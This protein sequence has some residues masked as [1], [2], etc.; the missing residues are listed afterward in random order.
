MSI[1][2]LIYIMA[3]YKLKMKAAEKVLV[4]NFEF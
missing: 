3:I 1:A 4:H 2:L